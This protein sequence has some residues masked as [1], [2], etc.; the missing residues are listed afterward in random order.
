MARRASPPTAREITMSEASNVV[1]V[2]GGFV[3][4]SGWEGVYHLLEQD[5]LNVRIVQN[6]T[7]SLHGDVA[8]TRQVLD[9]QDGPTVLV[10]HSY[11][12]A[13]VTEA[14]T[15]DNVVALV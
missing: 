10:G 5:G 15:H 1:L 13:V 14:G 6:P 4:G 3:D 12:G 11:G 2:H 8:A 7:L 9:Q